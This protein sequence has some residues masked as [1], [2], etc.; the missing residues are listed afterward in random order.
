MTTPE[1]RF[2]ISICI[3]I[4]SLLSSCAGAQTSPEP[5]SAGP[6]VLPQSI[7]YDRG[8]RNGINK[9]GI[10][11][12]RT[13]KLA[14]KLMGRDMPYRVVLPA[15]YDDKRPERYTTVYL[16]HGLTGH[17]ND[18]TDLSKA[19][20]LAT[21][22]RFIIVTPEGNNGWYSDNSGRGK[23]NYESYI[24]SELVPEV[25]KN[26][27]TLADRSH[28]II[29]GLSMGGYG[30]VKFGLK[31]PEMFMLVGSFSG[32]FATSEWSSRSGGNRMIGKTVDVALGPPGSELRKANDIFAL[33]RQL[34]PE[35]VSAL[36]HLYLSCG[37]Q[38][39][40]IKTNND[41]VALL[42][43][44]QIPYEF[45]TPS[46]GHDWTFWGAQL[47]QFFEVADRLLKS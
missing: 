41:F 9:G 4:A 34:T 27:R 3:V 33:T 39:T 43:E 47:V 25:D 7:N 18:W 15:G 12:I 2:Y 37:M 16:L 29:A 22:H 11:E 13:E 46:G 40:M 5:V 44:K 35:Q 30:A 23:D 14:S 10:G 8:T 45:R 26:Y 28:R 38:D 17:Y 19:A 21:T 20:E 6:A 1:R 42:K 31:H 32:A 36:P 24:I